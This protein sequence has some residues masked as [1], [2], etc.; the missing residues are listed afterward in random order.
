MA[1]TRTKRLM[2]VLY[3]KHPVHTYYKGNA[4]LIK[5][6]NFTKYGN[7]EVQKVYYF[8]TISNIF[9]C[10]LVFVIRIILV[11]EKTLLLPLLELMYNI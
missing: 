2:P 11:F 6:N 7:N 9:Q 10:D 4:C 3:K 8:P 5:G 1:Y